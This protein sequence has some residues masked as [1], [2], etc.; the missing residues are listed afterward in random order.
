MLGRGTGASIPTQDRQD[1]TVEGAGAVC[2]PHCVG[3]L[4]VALPDG[5][6]NTQNTLL[7][8][9]FIVM[10]SLEIGE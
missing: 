8:D 6:D 7:N 1:L 4:N 10:S 9:L 5:E 3:Y 2:R